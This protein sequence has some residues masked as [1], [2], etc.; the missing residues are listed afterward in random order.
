MNNIARYKFGLALDNFGKYQYSTTYD[1]PDL[2]GCYAVDYEQMNF[3]ERSEFYDLI[4]D[5]YVNERG[6]NG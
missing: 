2:F 1:P 5:E 6:I 3:S 4:C